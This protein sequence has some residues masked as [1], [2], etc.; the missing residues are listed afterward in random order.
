MSY[1]ILLKNEKKLETI[2]TF[3]LFSIYCPGTEILFESN[4]D[5]LAYLLFYFLL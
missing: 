1:V 5:N 3:I 2:S 4:K